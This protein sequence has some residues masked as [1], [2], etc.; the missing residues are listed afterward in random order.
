MNP[1]E[2]DLHERARMMMALGAEVSGG[3]REWLGEHLA[4][5]TACREFVENSREVIQALRGI[6]IMAGVSL[7]SATR[8]RVRRRAMELQQHRERLWV[9]CVCS[10]AVTLCT[11]ISTLALWQGFVWAGFGSWSELVSPRFGLLDLGFVTLGVM[12]A[13]LAGFVLLAH[14]THMTDRNE[15]SE[16]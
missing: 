9:I 7:V 2:K 13:V 15:S 12:P 6:P 4:S 10:V 8:E 11:A 14:G 16:G 3:E 1:E 5:C